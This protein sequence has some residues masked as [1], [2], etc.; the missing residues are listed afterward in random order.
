MG[1]KGPP[2]R[3]LWFDRLVPRARLA[4]EAA[5]LRELFVFGVAW[6]MRFLA[7]LPDDAFRDAIACRIIQLACVG[8]GG[9]PIYGALRFS[10]ATS[11]ARFFHIGLG[12]YMRKLDDPPEWTL[13]FAE[14]VSPPFHIDSAIAGICAIRA[15]AH[16]ELEAIADGVRTSVGVGVAEVPIHLSSRS[17][18]EFGMGL[19][20]PR[21]TKPQ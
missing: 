10:D 16:M 18:V 20:P 14:R 13:L 2:R 3:G 6:Q 7:N 19:F 8:D 12:S 17:Y 11:A 4:K 5:L 9:I 15:K 21:A 1:M